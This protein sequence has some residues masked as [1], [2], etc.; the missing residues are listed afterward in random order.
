MKDFQEVTFFYTQNSRTLP[1]VHGKVEF[2]K[3]T[4]W[5]LMKRKD[6]S[7]PIKNVISTPI[8][9]I[10]K[11]SYQDTA[12]E[13]P[14]LSNLEEEMKRSLNANYVNNKQ[15]LQLCED[16]KNESEELQPKET[17]IRHDTTLEEENIEDLFL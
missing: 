13:Q 11:A 14:I 6:Y 16:K 8:K 10:L 2:L 1:P 17:N 4:D 12:A 7:M 5:Q 15:E 3:K 9:T